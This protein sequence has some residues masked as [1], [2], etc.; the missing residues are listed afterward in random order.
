VDGRA[1]PF[2]DRAGTGVNRSGARLWAD[3]QSSTRTFW[4][5]VSAPH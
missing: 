4:P 1:G 2:V 3:Y 5:I